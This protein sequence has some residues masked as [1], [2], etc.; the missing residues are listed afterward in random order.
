MVEAEKTAKELAQLRHAQKVAGALMA[1]GFNDTAVYEYRKSAVESGK[2]DKRAAKLAKKL[3]RR[4][5]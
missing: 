5:A 2:K 4:A 3:A 1:Q